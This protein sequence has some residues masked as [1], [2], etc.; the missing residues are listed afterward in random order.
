S[1]AATAVAE[2]SHAWDNVQ[3]SRALEA[4]W[5]LIKAANSYLEQNE[6]WKMEPGDAVDRVMGDAL[7]ALRIVVILANP[8]LPATTQEIWERIGLTGNIAD[9][10]INTDTVWG[11]YPAGR[12]VLKGKPLYPRKTV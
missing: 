8:A 7:E 9:S 6:P 2:T 3:P 10:R 1:A 5:S 12:N 11:Q 4:T